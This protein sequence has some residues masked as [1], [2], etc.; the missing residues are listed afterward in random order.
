MQKAMKPKATKDIN[1][2]FINPSHS[3]YLVV[4]EIPLKEQRASV[5]GIAPFVKRN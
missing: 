2:M 1:G 3:T 4:H 5:S